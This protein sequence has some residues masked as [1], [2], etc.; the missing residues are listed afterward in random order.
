MDI[1]IAILE[2]GAA[3]LR[4]QGIAALTQP[5]VAAAA[6]IKQSHLTYYFPKRADLLLGIAT[7]T[8]DGV[9]N[10]AAVEIEHKPQAALNEHIAK[11]V[12][13]GVPP[14]VMIGLIVAAEEEPALRTPLRKLVRHVRSRIQSLLEQRGVSNAEQTALLL[15]ATI[16]GLAVLH[17]AQQSSTSARDV[18]SGIDRF[19]QQFA[20]PASGNTVERNAVERHV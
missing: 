4:D 13:N 17:H 3:L 12:T 1:R 11:A 15:H 8:I 14:R 5:K 18:R 6:G 9:L 7:H 10:A 2:A 16:V 20:A 19:F